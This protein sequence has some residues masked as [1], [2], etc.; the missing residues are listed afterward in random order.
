AVGEPVV[1]PG[2]FRARD[3]D[4]WVSCGG[5]V[6]IERSLR[7]FLRIADE[8]PATVLPRNLV[9]LG[10]ME[11]SRVRLLL[12]RLAGIQ[13]KYYPAVSPE[14]ASQILSTCAFAWLDYFTTGTVNP[15]LLLKSSS[16]ANMCA[17][18]VVCVTPRVLSPISLENDL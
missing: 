7:C 11:N 18:A 17:H 6:L 14:T 5:T 1:D 2:R 10:G 15:D 9:V 3:H 8:I 4:R 16:F 12:Q 13:C